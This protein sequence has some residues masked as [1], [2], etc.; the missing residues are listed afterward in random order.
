MQV[1]DIGGTKGRGG[2]GGA[3]APLLGRQFRAADVFLLP[4][5]NRGAHIYLAPGG[6]TPCSATGP[7]PLQETD[8]VGYDCFNCSTFFTCG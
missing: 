6:N 2:G 1:P 8:H 7:R 5:T 3:A 4:Y